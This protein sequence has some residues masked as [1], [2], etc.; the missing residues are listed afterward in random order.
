MQVRKLL[1]ETQFYWHATGLGIADSEPHK[2]E[3]FGI[4]IVEAYLHGALPIAI[5]AGGPLE[6]L[7]ETPELLVD[8]AN[9]M[10]WRTTQLLARPE[11]VDSLMDRLTGL[12]RYSDT[13]FQYEFSEFAKAMYEHVG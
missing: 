4:S 11:A 5:G 2:K 12:E 13:T 3:H 9:D 1:S 7:R 8:S 10:A 6:I